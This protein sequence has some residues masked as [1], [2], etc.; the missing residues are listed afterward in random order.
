MAPEAAGP[1]SESLVESAEPGAWAGQKENLGFWPAVVS[2]S[3]SMMG[4]GIVAFPFA[5]A[6]CGYVGGPAALCLFGT[7]AFQSYSALLRCT[8]LA[9][10]VSY[11][12]LVARAGSWW[13]RYTTWALWVLL[14]MAN[15]AYVIIAAHVIRSVALQ[16]AVGEAPP[17]WLS[18]AVLF[19][20]IVA[21][22]FPLCL[23]TSLQGLS[24]VTTYCSFAIFAVTGIII[25][26]CT[27][28]LLTSPPAP[29][30]GPKAVTEPLPVLLALPIVSCGMFGH[31]NIGQIYGEMLPG[32]KPRANLVA[33]TACVIVIA[34]Y[35]AVGFAG[36]AAF[37]QDAQSD[38]VAQLAA[39]DREGLLVSVGQ[40][41]L[42]SFIVLKTPLVV[43]PLRA[44]TLGLLAPLG[45]QG[46]GG[47]RR[48]SA[49]LKELP[50]GG[51]AAL[52]AGLL[53]CIYLVAVALPALD[54]LLEVLGALAVVPLCFVV[55]ARISWAMETPRRS[56]LCI[57]LGS[58]GAV[59]S[60][61]S[62]AEVARGSL[63]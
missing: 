60:A 56:A 33:L 40:T 61:L 25:W 27:E 35:A 43:F 37:G 39:H 14:V 57:G 49:S 45:G 38:I 48:R 54:T 46:P 3:V 44:V 59:V 53:A 47:P 42:T 31:M 7:M 29:S 30:S 62:L 52:T 32:V 11:G 22:I 24:L 15:A 63:S 8:A 13:Q 2:L 58:V 50:R 28:I 26:R 36:Y 34:F 21:V 41:L 18:N 19:A 55:P 4:T 51:N 12:E 10:E 5:F 20:L 9:R 1:M 6:L 23:T 16:D 17:M